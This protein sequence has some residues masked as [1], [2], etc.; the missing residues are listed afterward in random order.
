[1]EI[2]KDVE[3]TLLQSNKNA[4]IMLRESDYSKSLDILKEALYILTHLQECQLKYKLLGMTQSNLGCYYKRARLPKVALV[5]LKDARD[6]ERLGDV[7][8]IIRAGTLL[9]ICAIYSDL[10]LHHKALDQSLCALELLRSSDFTENLIS[11]LVIGYHNTGVEYEFLKHGKEALEYYKSAWDTAMQ[12]LGKNH[13][14]TASTYQSYSLA[15][16]SIQEREIQDLIKYVWKPKDT[17]KFGSP[18]M[19][20]TTRKSQR[21]HIG[22]SLNSCSPIYE[23]RN[24]MKGKHK[25]APLEKSIK[26]GRFL[27]NNAGKMILNNNNNIRIMSVPI[28]SSK[29]ASFSPIFNSGSKIPSRG[30]NTAPAKH[31]PSFIFQQERIFKRDT[32]VN[33]LVENKDNDKDVVNKK[34]TVIND[35]FK[36]SGSRIRSEG[37]AAVKIQKVFRGH[38][39]RKSRRKSLS[40]RDIH[41]QTLEALEELEGL[42]TRAKIENLIMSKTPVSELCD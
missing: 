18:V 23:K 1:M 32:P 10:G 3:N 14:L 21:K 33:N 38:I 11:T 30:I 12:H 42:K 41:R 6:S 28:S 35:N 40:P 20:S 16:K 29:G 31:Q 27:K 2:S 36:E 39:T 19:R 5:Y 37:N 25:L 15:T 22:Y 8:S 9:N 7:D 26:K 4:M 24:S 13:P 34:G 17:K